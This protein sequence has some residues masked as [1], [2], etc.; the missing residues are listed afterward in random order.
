MDCRNQLRYIDTKLAKIKLSFR[1]ISHQLNIGTNRKKRGLLN[2]IGDFITTLFGNPNAEDAEFYANSIS[3]LTANQRQTQTLMQQQVSVISETIT[4]FNE[5]LSRMNDNVA[6]LN[7]NLQYFNNL[8]T[9]MDNMANRLDLEMQLSNHML[10]LIEMTDETNQV[11]ENYVNDFS[12]LQNGLINFRMLPPE[13]LYTELQR[14]T[15]RFI[16]PL[17]LTI[18]N[19][20]TYYKLITLESFIQN[21]LLI[22]VFKIPTVNM[23]FYDVYK[24]FPLPT[25]H[26][27]DGSLFSYIEPTQP[28]ILFSTTRTTFLHMNNLEKCQEYLPTQWLCK[29]PPPVRQTTQDICEVQLFMKST[30]HIPKNCQTRTLVAELEI[31]HGLADNRWLFA[32]TN[33][34]QV[35]IV[36]QTRDTD[37]EETLIHNIGIFQLAADCKAYTA[38]TTIEAHTSLGTH[39]LTYAIPATNILEDDCCVK[40]KENLSISQIHLEPIRFVNLDLQELKFAQHKL[41]QFDEQL[42]QQLNKPFIVRKSHWFTTILSV[43]TGVLVCT[44]LYNL[45]KWCGL[46]NLVKMWCCFRRGSRTLVASPNPC[47]QIFN[48]C[49]TKRDTRRPVQ[50]HYDTELDHVSYQ[51]TPHDDIPSTKENP[52]ETTSKASLRRSNRLNTKILIDSM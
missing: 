51:D 4:N 35:T 23:F 8:T 10:L 29:N 18:D 42:Q 12:L 1:T 34:T 26:E 32:V 27:S 48:Q 30:S 33:P 3:S 39:N 46:F 44:I 45:A 14:L 6:T 13:I 31:W 11:L 5:S 20:Y 49:Y 52:D 2:G 25:P 15:T 17:P 9:E 40:L 43:L 24:M 41:Q 50:V 16:L 7:Q 37:P 19:I 22:V 38:H 47:L 21:N 28:Y 36:C